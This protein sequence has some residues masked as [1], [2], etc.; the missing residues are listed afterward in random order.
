MS[1]DKI[2][3]MKNAERFLSQ[4]KLR[5]AISEYKK[6]V[7]ENPKDF[8]TLNM[9]GDLYVKNSESKEAVNCYRQVAEHYYGQGFANKAIAIYNKIARLQPDSI[10]I[11]ERLAQL[12]QVRG[13]F[14]EAREQYTKVAESYQSK[15]RKLEALEIWKRIA[16]LDP[17]NTEVYI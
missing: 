8:S 12:Y 10:E 3:A 2:K 9:M 13:S 5:S 16:E 7:D 14:A 6:I 15:G 17:N 4:G 1:F 11:A